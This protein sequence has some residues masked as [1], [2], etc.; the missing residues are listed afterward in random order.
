MQHCLP[1]VDAVTSVTRVQLPRKARAGRCAR[2]RAASQ[3]SFADAQAPQPARDVVR[4][5]LH[6]N[7]WHHPY[8][9]DDLKAG[10]MREAKLSAQT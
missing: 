10:R 6:W 3:I 2:E 9:F 8:W 5:H 1:N 4:P 7:D